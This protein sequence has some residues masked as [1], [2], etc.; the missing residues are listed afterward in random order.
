MYNKISQPLMFYLM[1]SYEPRFNRSCQKHGGEADIKSRRWDIAATS[2][3]SRTANNGR[4]RVI[5]P[6][7]CSYWIIVEGYTVLHNNRD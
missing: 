3:Q 4:I 6:P 1:I 5:Y 2:G 7:S